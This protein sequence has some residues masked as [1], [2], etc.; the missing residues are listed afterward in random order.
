MAI[1]VTFKFL[2]IVV[3]RKEIGKMTSAE[4]TSINIELT[5]TSTKFNSETMR[6]ICQPSTALNFTKSRYKY[7]MPII[8]ITIVFSLL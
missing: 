2:V 3:D 4:G 7:G 6:P 5:V 8:V 1:A